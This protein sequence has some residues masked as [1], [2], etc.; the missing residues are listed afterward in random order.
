MLPSFALEMVSAGEVCWAVETGV[1]CWAQTT[2]IVALASAKTTAAMTTILRVRD[3]TF[4]VS[5]GCNYLSIF[6]DS[7][8]SGSP[9]SA[10]FGIRSALSERDVALAGVQGEYEFVQESAP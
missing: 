1:L 10:G 3:T 2:N 9:F 8:P 6:R 7:A 4:S 5:T